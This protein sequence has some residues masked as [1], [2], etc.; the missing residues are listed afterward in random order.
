MKYAAT[1]TIVLAALLQAANADFDLYRVGLGG[2]GISGN[3]EGWQVYEQD[4]ANCDSALDWIW[5]DSDDVSGGKF[6]V[7][8]EGD[9]CGRGFEEANNPENIEV[10]EMNFNREEHHWSKDRILFS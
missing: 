3:S 7:R 5:R 10:L 9:G 8:C 4:T 2:T 1:I 6:G